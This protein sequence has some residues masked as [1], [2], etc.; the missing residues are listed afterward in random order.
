LV[1]FS[2]FLEVYRA[3][4]ILFNEEPYFKGGINMKEDRDMFSIILWI[5]GCILIVPV[6]VQG[7]VFAISCVYGSI[8][9]L[10]NK[11]E[12]RNR[13]KKGIKDGTIVQVDGQFYEVTFTEPKDET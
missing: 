11:I 4:Y 5:V 2:L 8:A 1:I 6:L 7:I 10:Y 13:M 9:N 3:E 12:F